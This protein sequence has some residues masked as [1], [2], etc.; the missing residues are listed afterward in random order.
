MPATQDES[1]DRTPETG[2]HDKKQLAILFG[3]VRCVYVSLQSL[4]TYTKAKA[5]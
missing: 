2:I 1:V 4:L 5:K 3:C